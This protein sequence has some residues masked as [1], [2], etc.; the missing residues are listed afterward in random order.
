VEVS[1]DAVEEEAGMTTPTDEQIRALLK[2]I[3]ESAA[4]GALV[5]DYWPA[6]IV[7]QGQSLNVGRLD[8]GLVNAWFFSLFEQEHDRIEGADVPFEPEEVVDWEYT[9]QCAWTYRWKHITSLDPDDER[10]SEMAF[11]ARIQAVTDALGKM[12]KLGLGV[13][14]EQHNEL[15]V[16]KRTLPSYGDE[17]AWTGEGTLTVIFNQLIS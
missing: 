10:S 4:T 3:V 1:P 16:D 9:R 2:A 6:A 13:A 14:V 17:K 15:Q 12:P 8:S 11:S 5:Y 7:Q